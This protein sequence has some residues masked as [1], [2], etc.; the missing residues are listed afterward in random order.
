DRY[1]GSIQKRGENWRIIYPLPP[2]ADGKRKQ[3]TETVRGT[4]KQAGDRL[5][6]RLAEIENGGYIAQNNQTVAQYFEHFMQ[7]YVRT[8]LSPRTEQG[9]R[10]Y[11]R[12]HIVPT[13]GGIRLQ[14]LTGQNI[15]SL[16][17]QM[18]EQGLSN[19]TVLNCHRVLNKALVLAVESNLLTQNPA[20]SAK[21][22]RPK[23]RSMEIW[24]ADTF[25]AFAVAAKDSPFLPMY[26]LAVL[27][28]MRRSELCGLKWDMVDLDAGH[29]RVTRTLQ[30]IT[31]RGLVEGQ[32]KTDRSRRTIS[33]GAGALETLREL[34]VA[35]AEKRLAIGSLWR[36]TGHVFANEDG[37]PISG[38]RLS[39]NFARIVKAAALPHLSFHGLRHTAASLMIADGTHGRTIADIL[40]HSSITVTMDTYGHL[41]PGIQAAAINALDSQLSGS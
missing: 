29:L 37:S 5:R 27:T 15:Q 13:L 31:G 19:R 4:K 22:P 9:Y 38:D 14:N 35:Q 21:P 33:L 6:D 25:K 16:H 23:S 8:N 17:A 12:R 41:M 20:K 1:S 7:T 3:K 10:Y 34:R 24:E 28:G 18:L 39:K 32:P 30:P 36:G 2:G 40:G 11:I 26:R